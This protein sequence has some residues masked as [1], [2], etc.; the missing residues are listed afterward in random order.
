MENAAVLQ[1]Q[2]IPERPGRFQKM[3][4]HSLI[5]RDTVESLIM[6][7]NGI[8]QQ[9]YQSLVFRKAVTRKDLENVFRLRYDEYMSGNYIDPHKHLDI[10]E[11]TDFDCQS[12]HFIAHHSRVIGGA[13]LVI[14]RTFP[15]DRIFP[16]LQ[17][18]RPLNSAELTRFI[19][20]GEDPEDDEL[21]VA[22]CALMYEESTRAGIWDWF[23]AANGQ[24]LALLDKL[25]IHYRILGAQRMYLGSRC[26]PAHIDLR[27][28]GEFFRC[29][30]S[31]N[32][33]FQ[34]K[35]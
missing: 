14:G 27:S 2:F 31:V 21:A 35:N 34:K 13:K 25:G 29:Y 9:N 7:R 1:S 15:M 8:R 12:L 23:L 22:F 5:F 33:I 17:K 11:R 20:K 3:W 6:I 26:Q 18:R 16:Y 32:K 28:F 24:T 30:P 10:K 19:I 4:E